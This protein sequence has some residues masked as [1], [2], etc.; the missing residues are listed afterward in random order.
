MRL[1]RP[2]TALTWTARCCTLSAALAC[3]TPAAQSTEILQ[4]V[5]VAGLDV[6]D[7]IGRLTTHGAGREPLLAPVGRGPQ[8]TDAAG[9]PVSGEPGGPVAPACAPGHGV[10]QGGTTRPPLLALHPRGSV[11]AW[12]T[13]SSGS[14]ARGP[15]TEA[16]TRSVKLGWCK[17]SAWGAASPAA[18]AGAPTMASRG[19]SSEASPGAPVAGR[20]GIEPR[21]PE[22]ESRVRTSGQ[23]SRPRREDEGD[24]A[25]RPS[26]WAHGSARPG[27]PQRSSAPVVAGQ[28]SRSPSTSARTTA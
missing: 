7:L 5:V 27:L 28:P 25:P 26:P 17:R 10:L 8:H 14:T 12:S 1:L 18:S 20:R 11:A 16:P 15:R 9:G 21:A 4:P 22:L 24:H 23:P 3:V 2:L 13:T 6:V 19:R